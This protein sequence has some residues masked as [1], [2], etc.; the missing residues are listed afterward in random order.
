MGGR[1]MIK[2][3]IEK[4]REGKVKRDC[5]AGKHREGVRVIKTETDSKIE[6]FCQT[7]G[8]NL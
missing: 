3:L 5:A 8:V 1:T 6:K 2:K 7:C 4:W